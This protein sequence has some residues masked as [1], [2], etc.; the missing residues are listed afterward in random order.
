METAMLVQGL[1]VGVVVA[2]LG[3]IGILF[4][5]LSWAERHASMLPVD[6]DHT[7]HTEAPT[8]DPFANPRAAGVWAVTIVL[9]IIFIAAGIPKLGGVEIAMHRFEQ[10]GY[11]EW[12]RQLIGGAEFMGA[13]LLL[14]PRT[15]FYAALALGAIML[16]SIFTHMV[17]AQYA[18]ALIPLVCFGALTYIASERREAL[19]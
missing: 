2:A 11:P 3:A 9:S 5:R 15:A 1:R 4:L 8:L 18:M 16:G 13:I 14:I 6:V 7:R 12:F 19:P 10:W 17:H